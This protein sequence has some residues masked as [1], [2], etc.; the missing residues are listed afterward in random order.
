MNLTE[1]RF[2]G[3]PHTA[4]N[5]DFA[6]TRTASTTT[7]VSGRELWFVGASG[8]LTRPM[9]D[10]SWLPEVTDALLR[11]LNEPE[12]WDSYGANRISPQAVRVA[13][14]LLKVLSRYSLPEPLITG[15]PEGGISFEW[16][17]QEW[18]LQVDV[19]CN[20]PTLFLWDK[21]RDDQ[22]E[23]PLEHLPL[24]IG[25]ALQSLSNEPS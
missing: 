22:W 12:G 21:E 5:D 18:A 7:A 15:T 24:E 9:S 23:G 13:H 20:M 2:H 19:E 17:N 1:E 6:V 25:Y 11:W 3:S 16:S 8:G 4:A 14:R 10:T